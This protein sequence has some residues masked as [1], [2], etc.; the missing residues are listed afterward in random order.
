MLA[1][2][3]VVIYDP[4]FEVFSS[5]LHVP[6]ADIETHGSPIAS[7]ALVLR[8]QSSATLHGCFVMFS[9]HTDALAI[10]G[11]KTGLLDLISNILQ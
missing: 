4:L 8:L 9:I 5:L 11:C 10:H 3:Y 2:S 6:K 1:I 7:V